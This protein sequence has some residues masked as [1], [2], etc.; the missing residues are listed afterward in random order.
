MHEYIIDI[1]ELTDSRELLESKPP[2]IIKIFIY[3]LLFIIITGFVW[4]S[5][6]SIEITTKSQ[7]LIRPIESISSI[8]NIF[9]G[10]IETISFKDG[11]EV[12]KGDLLYK[13]DTTSMDIQ[14]EEILL[15][16]ERSKQDKRNLSLYKKSIDAGKNLLP[17]ESRKY[18]NRYIT[19]ELEKERL[20]LSYLKSLREL[21]DENSLLDNMKTKRKLDELEA[22]VRLSQLNIKAFIS[23]GIVD[24][25]NEITNLDETLVSL[26]REKITL[27]E[28]LKM[29]QV[30]AS[31]S[32]RIQKIL[33]LNPGD[34][35]TS[36]TE[37]LRLLPIDDESIKVDIMVSNKDIAGINIGDKVSY[38]FAALPQKEY[39]ILEGEITQIPGDISTSTSGESLYI[40]EGS[41]NSNKLEKNNGVV[42]FLKNGMF[43]DVRII[44]R[45]QKIIDYLLEKLDFKS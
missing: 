43:C 1:D 29:S 19:Y 32:G 12:E 40:L 2:L 44:S 25:E 41:L 17:E 42:V 22:T 37:V 36:G 21:E 4:I 15:K 23:S 8:K 26:N 28:N 39:G 27:E 35:L 38:R 45:E 20:N 11:E 13:I 5:V 33:D 30:R 16:I 7:G 31:I 34:Y 6:F 24:I 10:S 9:S 18:H 14:K 3:L